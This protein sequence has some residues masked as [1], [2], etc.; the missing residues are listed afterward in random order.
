ML[1][2]YI[3]GLTAST[4]RLAA[5]LYVCW[6]SSQTGPNPYLYKSLIRM[7]LQLG[8]EFHE[9]PKLC[10]YFFAYAPEPAF[11]FRHGTSTPH[12][13]ATPM[14]LNF[15]SWHR[16]SYDAWGSGTAFTPKPPCPSSLIPSWSFLLSQP[17]SALLILRLLAWLVHWFVNLSSACYCTTT[18]AGF[19]G[20]QV[21][22]CSSWLYI[23]N[24]PIRAYSTKS[25]SLC[26]FPAGQLCNEVKVLLTTCK[27]V[28][29]G[30]QTWAGSR[31]N[32]LDAF[33]RSH[34]FAFIWTY[35]PTHS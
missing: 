23:W 11:W 31:P 3:H 1:W 27:H 13:E 25:F 35:R 12:W 15:V 34:P 10:S 32:C 29:L 22:T 24:P 4:L 9:L 5:I 26:T 7:K 28:C 18:R 20:S 33:I 6:L 19:G 2:L 21:I 14:T 30:V 17:P 16:L 8:R